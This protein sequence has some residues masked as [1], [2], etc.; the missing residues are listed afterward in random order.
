MHAMSKFVFPESGYETC[1]LFGCHRVANRDRVMAP[2]A[3]ALAMSACMPL[4]IYASG[5]LVA[6][7]MFWPMRPAPHRLFRH[8]SP[9]GH[10][11]GAQGPALGDLCSEPDAEAEGWVAGQGQRAPRR[12]AWARTRAGLV[13]ISCGGVLGSKRAATQER[14]TTSCAGIKDFG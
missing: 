12:Q 1:V 11:A 8:L 7:H 9:L 6:I 3:I 14:A 4:C 10:W 2:S 5:A 13:G